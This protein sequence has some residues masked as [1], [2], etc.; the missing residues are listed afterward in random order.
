VSGTET[1]DFGVMKSS[2]ADTG[3]AL[4]KGT[5]KKRRRDVPKIP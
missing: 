4:T 2:M 1:D 5:K 3:T